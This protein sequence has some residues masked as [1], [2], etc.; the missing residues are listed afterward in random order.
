MMKTTINAWL[1]L[2]ILIFLFSCKESFEKSEIK[3]NTL[4][5][6]KGKI[7]KTY[8][9]SPFEFTGTLDKVV[10]TLTD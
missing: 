3:D 10:V 5:D 6:F 8:E 2:G 1:I 4:P 9:G 7:A